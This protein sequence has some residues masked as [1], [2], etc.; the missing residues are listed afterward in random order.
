MIGRI[1]L[2]QLAERVVD[3]HAGQL[4]L[5]RL[6]MNE[7]RS[8]MEYEWEREGNGG[9]IKGNGA[10][11]EGML[12]ISIEMAAFSIENSTKTWPFQ[13][14]FAVFSRSGAAQT[15]TV[16]GGSTCELG[17]SLEEAARSAAAV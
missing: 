14:K 16:G 9:T 12:R 3:C 8:K 11:M 10:K 5:V 15:V 13:S 6:R 2:L 1:S 17:R 7:N 4:I